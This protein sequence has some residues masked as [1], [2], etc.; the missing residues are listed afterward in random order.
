MTAFF[1]LNTQARPGI[2]MSEG[3]KQKRRKKRKKDEQKK[4]KMIGSVKGHYNKK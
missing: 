2:W 1:E 4:G 3:G